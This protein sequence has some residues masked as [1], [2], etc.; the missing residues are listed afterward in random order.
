MTV[1][2][3]V[4]ILHFA[5]E[6]LMPITFAVLLTFLLTPTVVRLTRWGLPKAFAIIA[7]VSLALAVTGAIGWLVADQAIRLGKELPNYEQ[8]LRRKIAELQ[9]GRAHV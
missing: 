7:T 6:V 2:L 5:R 1:V 3:L 4:A 9:I 8:N